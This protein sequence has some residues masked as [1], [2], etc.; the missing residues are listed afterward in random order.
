MRIMY[1]Y[2]DGTC[3]SVVETNKECVATI[4]L[5]IIYFQDAHRTK[6]MSSVQNARVQFRT[7]EFCASS[8]LKY[9]VKAKH[10]KTICSGT[11][12]FP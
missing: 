5:G 2:I 3:L 10:W 1:M 12:Y 9:K 6:R 11:I 8:T 4:E 7:H